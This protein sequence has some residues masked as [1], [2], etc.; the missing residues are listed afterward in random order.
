MSPQPPEESLLIDAVRRLIETSGAVADPH[1]QESERLNTDEKIP[2]LH[3][4]RDLIKSINKEKV[5]DL[6]T[7]NL[8]PDGEGDFM[9]D[10]EIF[11]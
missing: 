2:N 1:H 10:K 3:T 9:V 6:F 8:I 11:T 5:A 4:L 7:D